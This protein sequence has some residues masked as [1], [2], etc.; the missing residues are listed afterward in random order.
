M[1]Y[2][3]GLDIGTSMI[4]AAVAEIR[5]NRPILR[6]VFKEPS[7]GLRRGA[8]IEIGEVSPAISRLLR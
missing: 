6:G 8:V 4:K 7:V 5:N 1:N 3:V 2:I